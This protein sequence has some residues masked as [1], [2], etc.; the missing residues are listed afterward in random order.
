MEGH[1]DVQQLLS[2]LKR[3][4]TTTPMETSNG[5]NEAMAKSEPVKTKV[6]PVYTV[7]VVGHRGRKKCFHG[8]LL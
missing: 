1:D 7:K 2:P 6:Q 8:C 4:K 3:L 5:S